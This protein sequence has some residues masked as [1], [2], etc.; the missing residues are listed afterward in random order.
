VSESPRGP[1]D[2]L[3]ATAEGSWELDR[4]ADA[5]VD[6]CER[7][8]LIVAPAVWN[9][10]DVDWT[11]P[12]VVV[13][14]TWDYT[15]RLEEFL[16]WAESVER[17]ADLANPSPVLRWT[18]DKR[19]LTE[20]ASE[21]VRTVPG[22]VVVP[23]AGAP[24]IEAAAM[25]TDVIDRQLRAGAGSGEAVIK[26][27]VS[28]GS[29]DT[30]RIGT[31]DIDSGVDLAVGLLAAGRAVLVQPYLCSVDRRGETGLV[32]FDGAFSHA[33]TKAA[34]LRR[35]DG[36]VSGPFAEERIT[37][38]VAT[39]EER[40]VAYSALEVAQHHC[41]VES[42]LYARVDLIHDDD[43][44]PV[45]LELELC[46]PSFFS[47]VDPESADRFARAVRDRLGR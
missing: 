43:G 41:D 40:V 19:Y 1:V 29:K 33:F 2:V 8:G 44:D 22:E 34:I 21:G 42:L 3:F 18:T 32:F 28:A 16:R 30:L 17:S 38:A 46:E 10:P 12:L 9:D 6:A 24:D 25:V 39:N 45:V 13:R 27:T 35:G 4:D 47:E 11:V 26:P 23:V 37:P 36:L 20:L 14:S 7:L 15:E 31:D 5:L